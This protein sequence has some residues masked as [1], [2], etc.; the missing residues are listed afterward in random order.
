VACAA[1]TPDINLEKYAYQGMSRCKETRQVARACQKRGLRSV[2]SWRCNMHTKVQDCLAA[3]GA[4]PVCLFVVCLFSSAFPLAIPLPWYRYSSLHHPR[5][6]LLLL[7]LLLFSFYAPPTL[8]STLACTEYRNTLVAACS[9]RDLS[10][11]FL[12]LPVFWLHYFLYYLSSL[13]PL[14][15]F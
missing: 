15:H 7:L 12:V 11:L 2:M 3:T 9:H 6:L 1:Y 4:A 10:A 8:L 14:N 13:C 5:V